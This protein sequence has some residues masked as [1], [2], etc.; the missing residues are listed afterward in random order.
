MINTYKESSLHRTL[1]ELYA[2]KTGGKT[3]VEAD[4]HIYDILTD[5]DE[6]I[7]IQTQNLAKLK[8]K[9]LDSLEKGR[10]VKVVHPVIIEKIIRT[11]DENGNILSV[12]KSPKEGSVYSIFDEI[13]GIYN[14]LLL[15]NF[16]LEILEINMTEE[17][18]KSDQ[19]LQSEN[20][21]RRFKKNWN[22]TN[23][24]LEKILFVHTFKT[25]WDYLKLLP[26][27]LT[28]EFT[29]NDIKE[30][31]KNEKS[32]IKNAPEYSNLI[33]WTFLKMGLFELTGKKGNA[34][35]Y[36]IIIKRR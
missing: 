20:R 9:I 24:Y 30:G 33:A 5:K 1:K 3:E 22:K 17:R 10:K 8:E 15:K 11:K 29:V 21:R 7:E 36:R 4:G 12:R 23:K 19:L 13:K 25:A 6:V 34:K 28:E 32:L 35:V 26:T 27:T 16:T 2:A 31:L 18:I 14:I